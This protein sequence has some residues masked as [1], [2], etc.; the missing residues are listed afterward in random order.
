MPPR[1][2][3]RRIGPTWTVALSWLAG[4]VIWLLAY[5]ILGLFSG[6]HPI[7]RGNPDMPAPGYVEA[8]RTVT[9]S[10]GTTTTETVKVAAPQASTT[11][12]PVSLPWGGA[13]WAGASQPDSGLVKTEA[14]T[15]PPPARIEVGFS[16]S[17]DIAGITEVRASADD[18]TEKWIFYGASC[19]CLIMAFGLGYYGHFKLMGLAF[20][21]CGCLAALGVA[22]TKYPAQLMLGAGA[23]VI[24]ILSAVGW[25]LWRDYKDDGVLGNRPLPLST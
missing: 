2:I 1:T 5:A 6:C 3:A 13:W 18:S 12:T 11:G 21:G 7:S 19:V 23:V 22:V 25:F 10:D 14:N 20:L 17:Q 15:L 8:A 9:A 4:A 24:L 16:G